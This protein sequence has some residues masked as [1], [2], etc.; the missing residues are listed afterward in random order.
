VNNPL[1]KQVQAPTR[2]KETPPKKSKLKLKTKKGR[3]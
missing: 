1:G 2:K 3:T